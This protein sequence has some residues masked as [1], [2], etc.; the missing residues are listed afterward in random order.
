M[1]AAPTTKTISLRNGLTLEYV[2]QGN[3]SG[4]P[5]V[6]LHGVTDSWRSF[7]PV[8]PHLPDSLHVFAVTQR[9][10]G[11]S[12]HPEDGYRFADFTSDLDQFLDAVGVRAAVIVGH[13]MGSGVASRFA[14]D[15]PER[16]L[17]VVLMGS[18]ATMCGN[19]EIIDLWESGVSRLSEPV[20]PAFIRDFQSSTLARP[21]APA[22][23][24]MVVG[25]SRKVP[26][27]VWKAAFAHFL[28]ND[29]SRELHRITAPTLVAWGDR[30]AI[31]GRRD[32]D[33]LIA[34]ISDSRLV[35]YS[36]GG[37]AFHWE[38]P[39]A[40]AEDLAEFTQT[41]CSPRL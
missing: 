34:A 23:M 5:V 28:E 40:F 6:M 20:D 27:R 15:H 38:D 12:S 10:H 9:G 25:E 30:D 41:R 13:S 33:A 18:F 29:F 4:V 16:T 17:G 7:E 39:A 35:V 8:L 32:Q 14:I 36:D 37:H 3:A 21:V 31:F 2:E 22:F 26:L 11:G 19:P 1:T 24:D